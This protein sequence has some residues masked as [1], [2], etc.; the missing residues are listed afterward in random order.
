[1]SLCNAITSAIQV[2]VFEDS[3]ELNCWLKEQKDVQILD[4][5]FRSMVIIDEFVIR[6]CFLVIYK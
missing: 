4:I 5:K 2:R 3:E 1:M 6:D